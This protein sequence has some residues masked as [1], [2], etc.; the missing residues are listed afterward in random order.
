MSIEKKKWWH[1][2]ER[3][4]IPI[5]YCNLRDTPHAFRKEFKDFTTIYL[6]HIFA[7][8]KRVIHVYWKQESLDKFGPFYIEQ[9]INETDFMKKL[10]QYHFVNAKKL[11][12]FSK[13]FVDIDFTNKSNQE[14]LDYLK[15]FEKKY[16]D[17]ALYTYIPVIGTFA[18]EDVVEPYLREKLKVLNK[19]EKY[20]EYLSTLTH[21]NKKSWARLEEEDLSKIA[22]EIKKGHSLEDPEIDN[23][24]NNH[25]KKYCWLEVGY[26]FLDKPLTKEYFIAKLKRLI[27]SGITKLPSEQ[28]IKV[29]T[30]EIIKE[31][32]IDNKHILLFKAL[33][34]L[35]YLK[36][37]RDGIYAR[38][39]HELH[40]LIREILK[41]FNIS[42][43]IGSYMTLQEYKDLLLGEKLDLDKIKEREKLFIWICD[44][45]EE[46]L[47]NEQAEKRIKEELGFLGVKKRETSEI[48]GTVA[49]PG[50][51]QGKAKIIRNESELSKVKEG[52]I[53]IACM[54]KPS[55]LPAMKRAA[56]I[57]TDEG[58]ITCHASIVSRE[59]KVPCIIGTKTA[60]KTLNDGDE[61]EVDANRG[62]VKILKKNGKD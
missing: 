33:G 30:E 42:K 51:V 22:E 24:L 48:E 18:I 57:I 27:N 23:L 44:D 45:K 19:K 26:K 37:Y 39:H 49:S 32:S 59:L 62:V 56:A 20:G 35:I 11:I 28:D 36:E 1:W 13:T 55:Y 46:C 4:D 21:H 60:T 58:G 50:V 8:K 61:I 16:G 3:E 25:V 47:S 31:L 54:T 6:K 53:L 9:I 29:K 10:E 38:S 40:F 12:D 5:L 7:W 15:T 41:R 43:E 34:K 14:L 2:L 17:L 52:D